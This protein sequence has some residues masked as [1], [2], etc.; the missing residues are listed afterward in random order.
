MPNYREKQ[1][2]IACFMKS[3]CRFAAPLGVTTAPGGAVRR[4]F[5]LTPRTLAFFL[6]F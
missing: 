3:S 5:L 6:V 1:A 4:M 2:R